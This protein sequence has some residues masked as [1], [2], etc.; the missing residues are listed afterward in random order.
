MTYENRVDNYQNVPLNKYQVMELRFS[1]KKRTNERKTNLVDDATQVAE[2]PL[3]V[4]VNQHHEGVSLAGGVLLGFEEVGDQLGRVGYQMLKVAVNRENRQNRVSTNVRVT[5]VQA[6]L[7][8]WH[9]R[10]RGGN[11]GGVKTKP[12][13]SG[14]R[15]TSHYI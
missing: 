5:M 3:L 13:K 14:V 8:R 4:G 15:S 12:Y 7:D 9:Q 2:R 1:N 10:L 11:T 6:S